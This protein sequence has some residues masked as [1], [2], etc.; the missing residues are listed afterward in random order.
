M[1][2]EV[3]CDE[4]KCVRVSVVASVIPETLRVRRPQNE[5]R[6]LKALGL[7]IVVKQIASSE[8]VNASFVS[9]TTQQSSPLS[10]KE[11]KALSKA[12]P[13]IRLSLSLVYSCY[14]YLCVFNRKKIISI[15]TIYSLLVLAPRLSHTHSRD[16]DDDQEFSRACC[17]CCSQPPESNQKRK[18]KMRTESC[19]NLGILVVR[20]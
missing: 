17:C 18:K 5:L 6:V 10:I 3:S 2:V 12:L 7:V 15:M 1:L 14:K 8:F 11:N 13:L 20:N 16:Y 9:H 19:I 4:W